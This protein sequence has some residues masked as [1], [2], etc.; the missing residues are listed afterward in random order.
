M[1]LLVVSIGGQFEHCSLLTSTRPQ[2]IPH[3]CDRIQMHDGC[4][5]VQNTQAVVANLISPTE[6][7][8]H[9]IFYRSLCYIS[10]VNPRTKVS[11]TESVPFAE[12]GWENLPTQ[13]LM[14]LLTPQNTQPPKTALMLICWQ[15]FF[16]I[17]ETFGHL[18]SVLFFWGLE[19]R[20]YFVCGRGDQKSIS[21]VSGFIPIVGLGVDPTAKILQKDPA[22]SQTLVQA[23]RGCV[24]IVRVWPPLRASPRRPERVAAS[25][26]FA[27]SLE[28]GH[29]SKP[30]S[31][32]EWPFCFVFYLVISSANRRRLGLVISLLR[33]PLFFAITIYIDVA[34]Y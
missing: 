17:L 10:P 23:T 29:C 2:N 11:P 19:P 5:S 1:R 21:G 13:N 15:D 26:S 9:T 7:D 16:S 32:R 4:L 18:P 30:N 20:S 14:W 25:F 8:K 6:K 31:S 34:Y 3:F 12:R 22:L 28:Q 33:F 27:V 24:R